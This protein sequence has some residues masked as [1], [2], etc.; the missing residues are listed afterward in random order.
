MKTKVSAWKDEDIVDTRKL[1]MYSLV[2]MMKRLHY[3][4]IPYL[5]SPPRFESSHYSNKGREFVSFGSAVKLYNG[6]SVKCVFG[7]PPEHL[8][9]WSFNDYDVAQAKAARIVRSIKLQQCKSTNTIIVQDHRVQFVL[10]SYSRL[11]LNNKYLEV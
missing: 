11:F 7:R 1:Q 3:E 4:Y 10:E 2:Q 8:S 5:A 9:L 6:N